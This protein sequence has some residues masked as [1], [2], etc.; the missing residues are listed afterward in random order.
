MYLSVFSYQQVG[1][2]N[3]KMRT[4]DIFTEGAGN[5]ELEVTS[6]PIDGGS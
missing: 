2:S 6:S 1:N 3:E 5:G 4:Q